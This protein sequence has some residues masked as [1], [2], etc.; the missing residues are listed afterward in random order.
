LLLSLI[1]AHGESDW[2]HIRGP[3]YDGHAPA[4]GA[5]ADWQVRPPVTLWQR[6]IG[7]GYSGVIIAEERLFTQAQTLAGQFVLCLDLHTGREIWRTR[8]DLPWLPE[9]DWPGPYASPTFAD[10]RIYFVGCQGTVGCLDADTGRTVWTVHLARGLDLPL[11]AYGYAATPLIWKDRVI[12]PTAAESG[13]VL[14]LDAQTGKLLWRSG[15]GP[16]SYSSPIVVNVGGNPQL[17]TIL[18]N[19]VLGLDPVTGSELWQWR[20]SSGYDPHA[21]WPLYEEPYLFCSLPFRQGSR[22]FRLAAGASEPPVALAWTNNAICLDILSGVC[23][24]GKLY[25][26][27]VRDA[28][29]R[30]SG[31]TDALLKCVD[32]ASGRELWSTADAG[33]CS[34]L[35]WGDQLVLLTETGTLI[36]AEAGSN[37]YS[38]RGRVS[39]F[40]GRQCWT[41]PTI[42]GRYLLVRSHG[43]LAALSLS[44]APAQ[45]VQE[46]TG[47]GLRAPWRYCARWFGDRLAECF[48]APSLGDHIRWFGFCL[49]G[50]LLPSWLG[51]LAFSRGAP[52]RLSIFYFLVAVLSIAGPWIFSSLS[53]G[54]V[55]TWPVLPFAA[56]AAT[57]QYRTWALSRPSSA[58]RLSA[59]AGLIGFSVAIATYWWLCQTMYLL[60]GGG[61]LV[62]LAPAALVLLPEPDCSRSDKVS[63]GRLWRQQLLAFCLYFWSG[64]V[65]V[66][67]K[68]GGE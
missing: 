17:V 67:W 63:P 60:C 29:T 44:D 58:S 28:Q 35:A 9:G 38:E 61:Y 31:N 32:M 56:L 52:G 15:S 54:L 11:P 27:D 6:E 37:R 7:D 10:G 1:T 39:V 26:C 48:W 46:G 19:G 34:V 23:L 3:A 8:Y 40:P 50:V 30:S 57:L 45:P 4:V 20:W 68:T 47:T 16:C 21:S 49:F 41:P 22:A 42:A 65:F 53:S 55:F 2:P 43:A 51:S 24:D 5:A 18:E 33:H 59:R 66:M 13:A 62:G 14:A 64:A 12:L 36:L 25:A